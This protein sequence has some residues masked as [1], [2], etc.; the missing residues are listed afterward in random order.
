[1]FLVTAWPSSSRAA[2]VHKD[3]WSL[4]NNPHLRS[5]LLAQGSCTCW[6]S[7]NPQCPLAFCDLPLIGSCTYWRFCPDSPLV[8]SLSAPFCHSSRLRSGCP[9]GAYVAH[10]KQSLRH[11]VFLGLSPSWCALWEGSSGRAT[12]CSGLEQLCSAAF[13]RCRCSGCP[14]NAHMRALCCCLHSRL[15]KTLFLPLGMIG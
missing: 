13:R 14:H 4:S 12:V 8:R 3:V 2:C 9:G 15:L 5:M 10:S 11:S 7:G 6:C 1:M